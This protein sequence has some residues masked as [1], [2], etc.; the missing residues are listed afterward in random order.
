MKASKFIVFLL[1]FLLILAVFMKMDVILDF[2]MPLV[3]PKYTYLDK[4][5]NDY[6]KTDEFLFVQNISNF[7][8]FSKQDILNA[9]Y[10]IV[11]SGFDTFSFYCAKEYSDCFNDVR[12]ISQDE[13]LMTHVNNFVNP[14]NG[15]K[16][17][18][19]VI[20][21]SGEITVNV[22][23]FYDDDMIAKI[24]RRVDY[25]YDNLLNEQMDVREKIK[26]IHDYIINNTKYDEEK[27]DSGYSIYHSDTAIGPLF[28]GYATCNGYTDLMA[29]FLNKLGLSNFKVATTKDDPNLEGHVWNAVYLDGQWLHIDLTWDDPVSEDG[30]DYLL[31]TYFLINSDTLYN[32]DNKEAITDHLFLKDIYLELK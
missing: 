29:L 25:L 10:T 22:T 6:K 14:Y 12:E 18:Q 31:D 8:V 17:L 26:T 23:Y 20:H 2:I 1:C 3:E 7:L 5:S 11:N 15:F 4:P 27:K 32:I 24:N 16:N 9:F 30:K 28:E 19:T 13:A 21:E